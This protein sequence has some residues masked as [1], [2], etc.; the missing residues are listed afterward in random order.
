MTKKETVS[1][2]GSD[3]D[4]NRNSDDA[5]D[6]DSDSDIEL[7]KTVKNQKL[8]RGRIFFTRVRPKEDMLILRPRCSF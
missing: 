6:D 7:T 3:K 1:V 4:S 5:S 8:Y 2:I